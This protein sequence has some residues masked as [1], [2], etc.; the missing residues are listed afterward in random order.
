VEK[1]RRRLKYWSRG[2]QYG[3][4]LMKRKAECYTEID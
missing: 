2:D 1:E 4:V 3:R